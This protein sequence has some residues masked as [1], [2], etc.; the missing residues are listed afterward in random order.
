MTKPDDFSRALLYAAPPQAQAEDDE[1]D[2]LVIVRLLR[3][4]LWLIAGITLAITLL[5]LPGILNRQ[6]VFYAE[7]RMLI[8]NPLATT[9]TSS[10]EDRLV[11]LNL[12]TE[13]ERLMSRDTAKRVIEELDLAA[14][15][16]FNPALREESTSSA[17]KG[18]LRGL[19]FGAPPPSAPA[20]DSTSIILP[21]FFNGLRVSKE[22]GSDVVQIG[23]ESLDPELAAAVPNTLLHVYL[24]ERRAHLADEVAQAHA[25]IDQRIGEQH[26]RIAAATA[27]VED[28]SRSAGLNGKD[29]SDGIAEQLRALGAQRTEIGRSRADLASTI[30]SIEAA[31]ALADKVML[32]DSV[33][34]AT[35]GRDLQ[36]Q[37]YDLDRL[38]RIYG[39]SHDQVLAA[40]ARIADTS[41]QLA[42]EIDRFVQSLR[43]RITALDRADEGIA[44]NLAEAR[45]ALTRRQDAEAERADLQRQ[46][47]AEQTALERLEE[48]SRTLTA[49]GKLPVADVEMLSPATVPLYASSRGRSFYLAA[50][51]VLAGMVGVT[52]ACVVEMLDRSLRSHE[53]LRGIGGLLPAGL[54]PRLPRK[55]ARHLSDLAAVRPAGMF[56]GAV[57]SVALAIEQAGD[58]RPPASLLVTSPLPA[59]GKTVLASALALEFSA[60][61]Q[62]VLLVDGDLARGRVHGLFGVEDQPGLSDILAGERLPADVV[63]TDEATGIAFIPRG[64][65]RAATADRASLGRLLD[66]ARDSGRMLIIDSAPVL[67]SAETAAIAGCVERTLVVARWGST[68]RHAFEAAVERLQAVRQ[69]RLLVAI[70]MVQ[71]RRHALYGFKDATLFSR[72]LRRYQYARF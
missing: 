8:Q 67:G 56:G 48:Q 47:D 34:L 23:F 65:A 57:R 5:A 15:P 32:T 29:P 36:N 24:D 49:E 22:A 51:L 20:S 11:K 60:A 66:F 52:I 37:Q 72:S 27:A 59:E 68:S 9:L 16:E 55:M 71:P 2:A 30:A 35:I 17:I 3:R 64:N 70:N 12:T 54:V 14:R 44:A 18:S 63:R 25:W 4:R 69:D 43:S 19:L 33:A 6:P 45:A 42:T 26:D 46:V 61:G 1:L 50:A 31:P 13:V 40:R 53:Q 7:S 41:A 58:G 62:P 21:E 38:L 39:N 10:S 28:Y